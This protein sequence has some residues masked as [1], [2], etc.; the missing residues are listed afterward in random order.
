MS[1]TSTVKVPIWFWVVGG[2][3]LVW[4]LMGVVGFFVLVTKSPET[5]AAMPEAER[6]LYES[7]PFWATTA[8][9]VGVF[10]GSLGCLAMLLRK[11][12]ASHF[13]IAS[14]LGILVQMMQAFLMSNSIEVYG[15]ESLFMPLTIILISIFLV[16]FAFMAKGRQWLG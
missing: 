3:F 12:W 16:W 7:T 2:L 10:C 15:P 1:Q 13:F 6:N 9:A 4:N 5:L 11:S 8:F 14:L